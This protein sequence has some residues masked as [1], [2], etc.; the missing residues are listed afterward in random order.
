MSELDELFPPRPGGM[1]DTARKQA[2]AAADA[3][4][5]V[6]NTDG[7]VAYS[8]VRVRPEAP[9]LGTAVTVTLSS[10][11]PVRRL[12]P[13]D[14]Q[15]R[16]AVVL[17]VDNDVYIATSQGPAQDA[18]GGNGATGVFYLPAGIAI[19]LDTQASLWCACTTTATISRVSVL[20]TADS[21]P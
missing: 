14:A 20:V 7:P 21:A 18:A 2:A 6:D 12:L 17:A 9:D 19:P 8:A 3:A 11:N 10:A 15:R 1:V 4:S 16:S 13:Q 5:T